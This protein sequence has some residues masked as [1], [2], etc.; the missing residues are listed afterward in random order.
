VIA[1]GL[2]ILLR[3]RDIDT[4]LK[5]LVVLTVTLFVRYTRTDI[6]NPFF[7]THLAS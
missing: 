4:G 7:G 6:A 5:V 1:M 2:I 3:G